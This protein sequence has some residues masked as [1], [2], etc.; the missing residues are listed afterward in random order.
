MST[1]TD[2]FTEIFFGFVV[3]ELLGNLMFVKGILASGL[4]A[5]LDNE[6]N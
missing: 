1:S 3:R 5:E 2:I 4:S 6:E